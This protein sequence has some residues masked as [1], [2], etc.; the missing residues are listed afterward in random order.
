MFYNDRAKNKEM[1]IDL[2]RQPKELCTL[3][4]QNKYKGLPRIK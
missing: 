1:A 2:I 4:D 3:L